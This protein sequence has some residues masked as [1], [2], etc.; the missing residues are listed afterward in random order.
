MLLFCRGGIVLGYTVLYE[1]QPLSWSGGVP[2]ISA[3]AGGHHS[4]VRFHPHCHHRHRRQGEG[5]IDRMNVILYKELL[6]F[7]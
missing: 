1:W 2:A 7:R 4:R 5:A 6:T 3:H